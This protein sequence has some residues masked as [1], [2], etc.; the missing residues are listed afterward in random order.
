MNKHANPITKNISKID[1]VIRHFYT[2]TLPSMKI[3]KIMIIM[4]PN[5]CPPNNKLPPDVAY[6][7]GKVVCEAKSKTVVKKGK[8]F[9][10]TNTAD[11]HISQN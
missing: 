6:P 7:I 4:N 10:P 8:M 11:K 5:V 9:T 2:V 1:C 3:L